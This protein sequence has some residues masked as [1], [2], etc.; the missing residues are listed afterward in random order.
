MRE[1]TI[2]E[3]FV[4]RAKRIR[5]LEERISELESEVNRL[6]L[7]MYEMEKESIDT[8]APDVYNG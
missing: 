3:C 1:P 8:L 5:E 6:E 7:E 4:P 2:R